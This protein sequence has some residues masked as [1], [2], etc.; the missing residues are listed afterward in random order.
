M[1]FNS[2]LNASEI[3]YVIYNPLSETYTWSTQ[4]LANIIVIH[5]FYPLLQLLQYSYFVYS[6]ITTEISIRIY[7][8]KQY[9][10]NIIFKLLFSY[11]IDHK[12]IILLVLQIYHDYYPRYLYSIFIY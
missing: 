7:E 3:D 1:Y 2:I 5:K 9:G 12:V 10:L 8:T 11:L 6:W 4:Y